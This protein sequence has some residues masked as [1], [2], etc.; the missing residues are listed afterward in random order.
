M[1]TTRI[2]FIRHGKKKNEEH[3]SPLDKFGEKQANELGKFLKKI[4]INEFYC[5]DL[6]RAKKTSEIVSKHI[7]LKPKIV[8]ALNEF[9]IGHM[10]HGFKGFPKRD[11]EHFRKLNEFLDKITK[12]PNEEKIILI[13]SHGY[14]N[15]FIFSKFLKIN[16]KKTLPFMQHET[17]INEVYWTKKYKNWRL[18]KW[19]DIEH[20]PKSLREK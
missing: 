12:N 7:K 6:K 8:K 14:T 19:N 17:G 5:S 3:D 13:I 16:H 10:R 2:L 1:K 18:E 15:R 11:Q 20:L 4:K 9:E